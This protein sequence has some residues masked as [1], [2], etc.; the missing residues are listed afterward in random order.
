MQTWFKLFEMK[1]YASLTLFMVLSTISLHMVA[2]EGKHGV[3][4]NKKI[5]EF[6][7]TNQNTG[8]F[9]ADWSVNIF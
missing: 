5:L 8:T 3:G 9:G 7:E 6:V 1:E 2:V 4:P